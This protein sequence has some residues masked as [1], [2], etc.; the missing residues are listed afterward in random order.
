MQNLPGVVNPQ[1]GPMMQPGLPHQPGYNTAQIPGQ[2]PGA[3]NAAL[4]MIGDILRNPRTP[5][6]G[7]GSA[8]NNTSIQG[9]IAGVASNFKG[10]SIKIYKERQKYQ[11]W[12][13]VYDIKEDPYLRQRGA[14]SGQ[15]L[16]GGQ[17][18]GPGGQPGRERQTG[19]PGGGPGGG[20]S[21][22]GFSPRPD[23][24]GRNR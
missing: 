2:T 11:E 21:G 15:Q 13:F 12:E 5:P 19:S 14:P 1:G 17:L 20:F 10:P 22:P 18:G 3:G 23:T 16:P 4:G 8:F 7:V 24:G 9:G 6:A